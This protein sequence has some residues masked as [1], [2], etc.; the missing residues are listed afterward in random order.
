[1]CVCVRVCVCVCVYFYHVPYAFKVNL[2]SVIES[3]CNHLG[4][5]L[6]SDMYRATKTLNHFSFY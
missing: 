2:Q 3:D 1:M 5:S 4:D 6:M